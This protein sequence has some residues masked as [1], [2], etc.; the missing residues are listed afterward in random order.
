MTT[1]DLFIGVVSYPRSRFSISR[2]PDGLAALLQAD[3]GARGL[4]VTVQVNSADLHDGTTLPVTPALVQASLSAQRR[5]EDAW[6]AYVRAG[7]PPSLADRARSA[8]RWSRRQWR[9][10]RPPGPGP[11]TRLINI[12]L[13][14]VDLLRRGHATGAPWLLIAEDDAATTDLDDCGAGLAALMADLDPGVSFVNVSE[15]FPLSELRIEH[16]LSGSG[17][18]WHG[19][20]PR[21]VLAASRPVTNT[22][23]AILYRREFVAALLDWFDEQPMTPVVPID[24]KLNQALM[25]LHDIGQLQA[26]SCLLVSP[27]P[28]DQLSM[29]PGSTA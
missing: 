11:V 7:L 24:W 3:L 15:S 22:V 8:L 16:L 4:D 2:G 17:V 21:Q 19:S 12:E 28:I 29:R 5:L 14:H 23:C 26:D 13:S 25:H 6:M 9:R 1:P 27:A 10:L 18:A 20:T